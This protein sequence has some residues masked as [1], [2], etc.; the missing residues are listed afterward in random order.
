MR[1]VILAEGHDVLI[2]RSIVSGRIQL[3][4]LCRR[5]LVGGMDVRGLNQERL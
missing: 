1:L 4:I 5:T 3:P 2:L